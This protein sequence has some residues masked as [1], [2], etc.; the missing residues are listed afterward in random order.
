MPKSVQKKSVSLFFLLSLFALFVLAISANNLTQYFANQKVL[1]IQIQVDETEK[2]T[3]EEERF[4]REFLAKNP[5][6]IP[7]WIEIGNLEKVKE[8]DPNYFLLP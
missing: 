3:Q 5:D 1:G 4:W 2:Q 8:I 7:G 6:Y